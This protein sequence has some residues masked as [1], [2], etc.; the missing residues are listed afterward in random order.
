MKKNK[1]DINSVTVI[2]IN[3]PS[4]EQARIKLKELC[5]FLEKNSKTIKTIKIEEKG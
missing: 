4:K 2:E 5:S 3:K 1:F